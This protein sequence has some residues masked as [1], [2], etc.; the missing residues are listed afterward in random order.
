MTTTTRI[1]RLSA[2]TVAIAV[3]RLSPAL[4]DQMVKSPW[5]NPPTAA[6]ATTPE[7]C[8]PAPNLPAG[9]ET[10]DYY[11]DKAHSVIDPA[12]KQAYDDAVKPLQAA[13]RKIEAMA[14]RYRTTGDASSAV[15]AASW[16]STLARS[17]VLSGPMSSNQAV[18][19]QGWMLGAFSVA[20]LK[21]RSAR[22]VP[23][24]ATDAV[25]HWLARIAERN[26]TYYDD[27]DNK[28]DGRNNHRYWS[29][30]AA[31]AAGIAASREDLTDWGMESF[32]VGI[33]Q[34]RPDG[35]LPLEMDRRARALHYHLFAAAPLVTIAELAAANGKDLYAERNAALGRLVKTAAASIDNP[36]AFDT[37]A[38][39][40]QEEIKLHADDIAW[41]QPF[42]KRFPDPALH[43]LLDKLPNR[44]ILYLGGLPP[45]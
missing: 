26:M 14:D 42:E 1:F 16:L 6:A 36:Q 23:A 13:A 22:G 5:D 21:V 19:V 17:G 43:A 39:V 2:L 41:A 45:G 7:K 31:M 12:R 40:K 33:A 35:T 9:L 30:F 20:W 38:G 32:R 27:R 11:S 10:A 25:P 4:A 3:S 34:I 28:M 8:G 15:C 44:S 37:K 24:S 29:G 18:Y